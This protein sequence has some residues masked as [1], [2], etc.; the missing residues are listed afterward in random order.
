MDRHGT[1]PRVPADAAAAG[2]PPR[3]PATGTAE[4]FDLALRDVWHDDHRYLVAV[5]SRL[6]HDSAEADDV[7][8]EAFARL[9]RVD[10]DAID[11]PRAWLTVVVRRLALN[12]LRSAYARRESVAGTAPPDG[13]APL[14]QGGDDPS[15]RV[16]LDEQVRQALA[17]VLDRL[18]PAE[19]T[20]FVLHDVFGFSHAVIGEIVGRTPTACRQLASRARRAVRAVPPTQAG[21]VTADTTGHHSVVTERFIAACAGG[22]IAELVAILDP[23]VAG[24]AYLPD[25]RPLGRR[26]GAAAVAADAIGRFGPGTGAVLVPVPLEG[27]PGVVAVVEGRLRAV[28]RLDATD[29]LIHHIHAVVMLSGR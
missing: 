12:R 7:V 20:A 5:A 25:R 19:R 6:L 23:D 11:D 21:P 13:P 24:E 16:T 10:L 4:P 17:V 9:V 1:V 29:G 14:T 22:D 8:Q 3:P 15:D 28:L 18:T 27:R 2:S 26:H